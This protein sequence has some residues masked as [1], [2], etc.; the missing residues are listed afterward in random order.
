[1][2]KI[3]CIKPYWSAYFSTII[4]CSE[5][6]KIKEPE[7]KVIWSILEDQL[8]LW[9]PVTNTKLPIFVMKT[10]ITLNFKL[11]M[12]EE[13]VFYFS[14]YF[15]LFIIIIIIWVCTKVCININV[16]Y[17]LCGQVVLSENY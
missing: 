1:M 13:P 6:Y 17:S 14:L 4:K 11:H 3:N 16:N 15:L 2:G 12:P 8:L 9:K 5:T 7:F 10:S